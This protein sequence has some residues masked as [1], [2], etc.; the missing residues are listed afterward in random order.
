MV[1]VRPIFAVMVLAVSNGIM[2]IWLILSHKIDPQKYGGASKKTD[3]KMI[4]NNPKK[5]GFLGKRY[6]IIKK[7]E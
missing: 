3:G 2:G 1:V 6:D 4:Q 7:K 5:S